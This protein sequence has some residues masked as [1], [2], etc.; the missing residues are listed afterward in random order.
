M[1]EPTLPVQQLNLPPKEAADWLAAEATAKTSEQWF[2]WLRNNRIPTRPAAW[3]MPFL[4]LGG[5]V[6]YEKENLQR[7]ARLSNVGAGKAKVLPE[8][9]AWI[10]SLATKGK[11]DA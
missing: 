5:R 7:L 1:T 8:D 6:L 9:A 11:S 2:L 3:R 4:K 10:K